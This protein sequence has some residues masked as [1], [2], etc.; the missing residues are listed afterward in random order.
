MKFEEK[1]HEMLSR[2][3]PL[4]RPQPP[5]KVNLGKDLKWVERR[6]QRAR[7][8]A[9]MAG[10]AM[11]G[12]ET[13]PQQISRRRGR[14][15][16]VVVSVLGLSLLA[17]AGGLGWAV[18]DAWPTLTQS[19]DEAGVSPST[20]VAPPAQAA[21]AKP[22]S[23]SPAPETDLSS[24]VL[25]YTAPVQP[26]QA[27]DG[28]TPALEMKRTASEAMLKEQISDPHGLVYQDVRTV[29]TPPEVDDG[30]NFCGNVNSLNPMGAYVGYQRF[31]SSAD[32]AVL[33]H[34]KTPDEFEEI[35]RRRCSGAQ[36]PR[37]WR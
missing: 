20:A 32:S 6:A 21:A 35:W 33:E 25:A 19:N 34:F 9:A 14:V 31:V 37:I 8:R 7:A 12:A 1:I 5:A 4:Q 15:R 24:A 30:V 28:D 13:I 22:A 27:V 26:Q 23:P 16:T 17:V 3:A 11:A 18:R 36:G 10:A 2:R 29:L